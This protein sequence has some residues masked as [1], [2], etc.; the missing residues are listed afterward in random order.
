MWNLISAKITYSMAL[1]SIRLPILLCLSFTSKYLEGLY[2]EGKIVEGEYVPIH[3]YPHAVFLQMVNGDSST[4]ICGAS[5]LNQYYLVSVAHCFNTLDKN[6]IAKAFAGHENIK[7][8][9]CT[10]FILK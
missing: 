2:L 9:D 4:H 5:V 1:T 7:K 8:V 6:G 10:Y 3:N